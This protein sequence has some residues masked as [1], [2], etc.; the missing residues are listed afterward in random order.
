MAIIPDRELFV[1][2]ARQRDYMF[3]NGNFT[4]AKNTRTKPH[5]EAH[6][7]ALRFG[8]M[9]RER[10]K[11]LNMRQDDVALTTGLGRRFI[12]DLEAGKSSAQLGKALLVAN[13]LG[14]RP[15]DLMR[16]TSTSTAMLP[17]LLEL[18]DAEND[19]G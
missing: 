16:S 1:D 4:M 10:R 5:D 17:D 8:K 9:I 12:I 15:T 3:L 7:H 6:A 11:A 14:L 18:P 19:D 13:A 2:F